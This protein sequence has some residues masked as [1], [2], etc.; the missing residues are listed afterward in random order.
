[1]KLLSIDSKR[2]RVV[3][4]PQSGQDLWRLSEVLEEGDTVTARTERKISVGSDAVV[5]KPMVLSLLVTK[6]EVQGDILRVAG[7]V[8][9]GTDDVPRGAHHS[10][11]IAVHD[12]LTIDKSG[13]S[14]G[15]AGW[16][17]EKIKEE[18]SPVV[19][20]LVMDREEATFA[21][22]RREPEVLAT[23]KGAVQ[24]K[25]MDGGSPYWQELATMLTE[26]DARI[27]PRH[28]IVA[29]PAFFKEYVL[30][31]LP[32]ELRK[33]TVAAT[34]SSSGA[35]AI[36]ELV[37]RPEVR[38]VLE[39]ERY[40]S[41]SVLVDTVLKAIHQ[42]KG[43]WGLTEVAELA[44]VGGLESVLVTSGFLQRARHAGDYAAVAQTLADAER[45]KATVH[46]LDTSAAEQVE[47]LG[48]IAAVK[49]W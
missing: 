30:Q 20:L 46:I 24:K 2:I 21:L 1:M 27:R 4:A 5:R 42:E 3:L 38:H 25:G 43:A 31:L 32:D 37:R 14:T 6:A 49:R 17:V 45:T 7:T 26:H 39:K 36:A 44:V 35:A 34:I 8:A 28:V 10:F 16:Q 40:S 11:S 9:E 22:L 23:V 29:S 12:T 33:K 18:D 19:L 47:R 13:S 41:E 48:G 15:W